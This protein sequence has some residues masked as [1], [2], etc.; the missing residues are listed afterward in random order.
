LQSRREQVARHYSTKD[1]FRQIPND[2][3]AQYFRARGLFEDL[4]FLAMKETQ[5][6]ELFSAW[7]P[8]PDS[9]RN[10][11]DTE[12]REIFEMS[13]EKGFR[14]IKHEARKLDPHAIYQGWWKAYRDLKR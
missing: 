9:Q 14:A 7:L 4:D 8:L 10:E 13:S 6:D 2:L 3:L 5:P 11:M 12:F 1:F